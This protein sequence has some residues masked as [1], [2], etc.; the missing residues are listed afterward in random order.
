MFVAASAS[1]YWIELPCRRV[2]KRLMARLEGG[3]VAVAA[4]G[5][6]QPPHG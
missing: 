2:S 1:Y 6:T 4:T 3:R 5:S